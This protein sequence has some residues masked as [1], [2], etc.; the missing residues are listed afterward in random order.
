MSPYSYHSAYNSVAYVL[1]YVADTL[2]LPFIAKVYAILGPAA[3]QAVMFQWKQIAKSHVEGEELTSHNAWD[4]ALQLVYNSPSAYGS[5][6]FVFTKL[7]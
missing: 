7:Y 1:V 5:D 4:L 2:N 6:D 3:T